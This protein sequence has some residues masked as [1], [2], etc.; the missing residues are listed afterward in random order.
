M[1]QSNTPPLAA[2]LPLIFPPP[3]APAPT[4]SRLVIVSGI[5]GTG[6]STIA[7]AASR[8]TGIPAFSA[9]W[10]LG[11]LTPFGGYDIPDRQMVGAELLTTLAYR[12]L[13]LGQ[14]AILDFPAEQVWVRD[15]W[16]SL[17]VHMHS[18][19]K[20]VVCMC[21]DVNVQIRRLAERR[22]DI[23]GWHDGGNL[24]SIRDRVAKFPSWPDPALTLDAMVDRESNIKTALDFIMSA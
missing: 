10:L 15:R 6:K 1:A 23:A 8:H 16:R 17:A 21:S 19:F 4:G 2:R 3:D 13:S 7:D 24:A 11:A 9:D 5:P 14:S 12:Q 22:R 20:V 18:A